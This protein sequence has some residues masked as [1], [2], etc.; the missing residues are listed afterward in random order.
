MKPTRSVVVAALALGLCFGATQA[1]TTHKK[2]TAKKHTTKMAVRETSAPVRH[3]MAEKEYLVGQTM[4]GNTGLLTQETAQ[5]L[6]KSKFRGGLNLEYA[7][8]GNGFSQ[9]QIRGGVGYGIT[10]DLEVYGTLPF[11]SDSYTG[12][13]AS[14]IGSIQVGGKY[15][16]A[17]KGS[18]PVNFG[19]GADIGFAGDTKV[20]PYSGVNI[21]LKG[22]VTA[23]TAGILL[24]GTLGFVITGSSNI[25]GLGVNPNPP[26]NLINVTY[27]Y[28]PPDY[29]YLSGGVGVPFTPTLTGIAELNI[30]PYGTDS[31]N[32]LAGIRAGQKTQLQAGLTIGIGSA[33]ADIGLLAGVVF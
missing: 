27:S 4:N 21:G 3:R 11:V 20:T 17:G 2:S 10:K 15:I 23:K 26:Y 13:S 1:Q 33:A 16:I 30:N 31:S 5:S 29:V 28:N 19:L 9:F 7:S 22:M 18:T 8:F 14:G 12:A 24:N 6:P 25:T 32:I